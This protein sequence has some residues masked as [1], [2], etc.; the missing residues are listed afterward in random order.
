MPVEIIKMNVIKND[1]I[2][3]NAIVDDKLSSISVIFLMLSNDENMEQKLK[4]KYHINI[5]IITGTFIKIITIIIKIP[6]VFFIIKK[7]LKT[8]D[9]ASPTFPPT[10]G[11]NVPEINRIP[12]NA[13]LS[14]ERANILCVVNSPV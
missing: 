3:N 13:I 7:L 6:N 14:E 12:F 1:I 8:D 9:I 4:K 2:F 5:S 11:I 10:I